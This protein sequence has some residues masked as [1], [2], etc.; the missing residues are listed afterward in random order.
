LLSA[1]E[2][3]KRERKKTKSLQAYL[4]E[5]RVH[6]SDSKEVEKMITKLKI[7]V[8]EYKRIKETLIE[9]VE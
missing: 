1:I 8:E 9:Q 7:Q 6:N 3:I 2:V 4:K 5:T